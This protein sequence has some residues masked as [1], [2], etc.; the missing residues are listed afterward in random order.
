MNK[1]IITIVSWLILVAPVVQGQEAVWVS[2]PGQ[3]PSGKVLPLGNIA[4]F[5]KFGLTS[6]NGPD[7]TVFITIGQTGPSADVDLFAGSMSGKL[8]NNTQK[9]LG[10]FVV[11]AGQTNNITVSAR[12]NS[13]KATNSA[14]VVGLNLVSVSNATPNN[15]Q[16]TI[17]IKGSS[18][19]VDTNSLE[20]IQGELTSI[21]VTYNYDE[22]GQYYLLVIGVKADPLRN[23]TLE[24]STNMVNWEEW[25]NGIE[26]SSK[27]EGEIYGLFD[28]ASF[29]NQ[30]FFR[31]KSSTP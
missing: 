20:M 4:T 15:V 25:I 17:P 31:L 16:G 19:I 26:L 11:K 13:V 2:D 29:P 10:P 8:T 6:S 3:L 30:G 22:Y 18:V 23:Y 14:P 5:L 12:I 9:V 21:S 7:Q 24:H 1:L 28:P 27:G